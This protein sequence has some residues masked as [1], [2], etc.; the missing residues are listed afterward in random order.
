VEAIARLGRKK[1]QQMA[2]GVAGGF[3]NMPVITI[4]R[5]VI[6]AGIV[7]KLPTEYPEN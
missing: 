3:K 1:T 7:W 5:N 6:T 2:A 4:G